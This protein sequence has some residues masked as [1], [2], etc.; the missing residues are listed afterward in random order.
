MRCAFTIARCHKTN[1]IR[2]ATCRLPV[3]A[4]SHRLCSA[5]GWDRN[6]RRQ[7]DQILQVGTGRKSESFRATSV[8][9]AL[10]TGG[11]PHYESGLISGLVEQGVKLDVVGGSD[12]ESSLALRLPGV[13]FRNLY[14][15]PSPPS[16][17]WNR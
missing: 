4:P 11:A 12:L 2:T 16:S 3:R 7:L 6:G 13:S 9:I 5:P 14:G 1:C 10:I 17:I 15:S 8:K